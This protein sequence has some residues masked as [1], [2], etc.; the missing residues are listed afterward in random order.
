MPLTVT[1]RLKRLLSGPSTAVSRVAW[2]GRGA[3]GSWRFS[4]RVWALRSFV[5]GDG[6]DRP[7]G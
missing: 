7:W 2:E 5:R 6:C 1:I 4:C 3:L